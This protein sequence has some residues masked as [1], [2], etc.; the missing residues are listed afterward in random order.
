LN[1][2]NL[3]GSV[4][5]AGFSPSSTNRMKSMRKH[6]GGNPT[7]AVGGLGAL[8][9]ALMG[10]RRGL[11]GAIRGGIGGGAMAMLDLMAYQALRQGGNLQGPD[12]PPVPPRDGADLE[13]HSGLVLKAMINAAKADGRIDESTN[14]K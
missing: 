5:Q 12:A 3:L 9:G 8:T 1:M 11:G 13:R 6:V 10:S 7:A 14:R 4:F 2:G